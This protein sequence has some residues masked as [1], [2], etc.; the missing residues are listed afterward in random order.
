MF[1]ARLG[2]ASLSSIC[3]GRLPITPWGGVPL[4]PKYNL[5]NAKVLGFDH[6]MP[7]YW[8][9]ELSRREIEYDVLSDSWIYKKSKKK[10]SEGEYTMAMKGD[11]R[12]YISS[13]YTPHVSLTWNQPVGAAG[14][15]KIDDQSRMTGLRPAT[16]HYWEAFL[17]SNGEIDPDLNWQQFVSEL[18]SRGMNVLG[19]EILALKENGVK[20]GSLNP[21]MYGFILDGERVSTL[22]EKLN[23]QRTPRTHRTSTNIFHSG[24]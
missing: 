22:T 3:G 16:G 17:D 14:E 4:E 21:G 8:S 12:I 18:Q 10:I 5:A 11:G 13:K 19:L 24:R 6:L 15:I 23:A 20:R 7:S 9:F 2:G 1:V